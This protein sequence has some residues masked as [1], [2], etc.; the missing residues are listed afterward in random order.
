MALVTNLFVSELV[1]KPIIDRG[2]HKVNK[3]LDIVIDSEGLFPMI[4]GL[5]V[6]FGKAQRMIPWA[7][8]NML[9][10]RFV[11]LEVSEANVNYEA[12]SDRQISLSAILD[13]QI[14]DLNGAKLVRVNDIKL[15][16]DDN[17]VHVVSVDIGFAGV[18]RRLL[19]K[20]LLHPKVLEHILK[21]RL[22][23]WDVIQAL[24]NKGENLALKVS[25]EKL[26]RIHPADLAEIVENISHS[27]R[28]ELFERL[29]P[30]FAADTLAEVEL[31]MQVTILKQMNKDRAAD[32]LE[33]MGQDEAADLLA[34]LTEEDSSQLLNLMEVEEASDIRGLLEYDEG[35]A[36]SLM[37]TDFIAF[38][39][40]L[41][42][43]NVIHRLRETA[44]DADYIYYLYVTDEA[45][46]LSGVVSLRELIVNNPTKKLADI[47]HTKVVR[48]TAQAD[49][50]QVRRLFTK[51]GLLALPVIDETEKMIGIITV[52]DVLS[53]P[54][55]TRGLNM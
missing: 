8:V 38:S 21:P 34:E 16:G 46:H 30:E 14:V 6:R 3:V 25:S 29:T 45:G 47:I 48:V 31:G 42:L 41:N 44:P 19:P 27:E 17:A 1:G 4:K 7:D 40:E 43:D 18:I 22:I 9:N 12:V 39:Q 52:D 15:A 49:E 53:L 33:E 5:V 10:S 20:R 55:N 13:R 37:T 50:K 24:P 26:A 36:G 54:A 51:Y 2:G 32:I 23:H 11:T 35:T 28:Q